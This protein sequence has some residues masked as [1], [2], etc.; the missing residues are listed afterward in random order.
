MAAKTAQKQE[1]KPKQKV[2]LNPVEVISTIRS[3]RAG[4]LF[5][6]NMECVDVLLAQYDAVIAENSGL[7]DSIN[8]KQDE[9]QRFAGLLEGKQ[10]VLDIA[11]F[12]LNAHADRLVQADHH[13]ANLLRELRTANEKVAELTAELDAIKKIITPEYTTGNTSAPSTGNTSAPS[14][15]AVPRS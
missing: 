6:A 10:N 7:T 8:A 2:E 9:L 11:N 14:T 15:G 3:N 4:K 12:E 5:I 13:A 1:A